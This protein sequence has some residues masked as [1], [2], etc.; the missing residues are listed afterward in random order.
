MRKMIKYPEILEADPNKET[1]MKVKVRNEYLRRTRILV[2]N[3]DDVD[4]D[5][6]LHLEK[7]EQHEI[8]TD[9][10]PADYIIL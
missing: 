4:I 8:R 7:I 5:N 3:E 1:E 9:R 6:L 2:E 10:N